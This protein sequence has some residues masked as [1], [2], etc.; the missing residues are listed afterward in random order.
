MAS[1]SAESEATFEKKPIS[2]VQQEKDLA[3]IQNL[4]HLVQS[5]P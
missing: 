2:D 1:K 3:W 5:H 4:L